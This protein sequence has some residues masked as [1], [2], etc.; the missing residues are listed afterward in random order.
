MELPDA[1]SFGDA[2]RSELNRR[3]LDERTL[4][5]NE[6]LT[7]PVAAQISEQLTVMEAESDEPILLMI[8]SVRE[9]EV[10]TGLSLYDLLRSLSASVSVLATGRIV[11]PGILVLVGAPTE[12]RFSLPNA[13]FR[14]KGPRS[15]L[16]SGRAEDLD[17][18]AEEVQERHRR[19]VEVLTAATGQPDERVATDLSEERALDAEEAVEYG[20]IHRVVERRDEIG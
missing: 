9:G 17:T 14:L 19:V 20:L 15:S 13:R 16:S 3:L 10:E 7:S 2:F 8:N 1:D 5:L 18:E 6:A 4:V 11:G 12:R